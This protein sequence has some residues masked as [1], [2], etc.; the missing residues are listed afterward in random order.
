MGKLK[1][2]RALLLFSLDEPE[3]SIGPPPHACLTIRPLKFS[4]ASQ[5]PVPAYPARAGRDSLRFM[6]ANFL[7]R[8]TDSLI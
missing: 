3:S 1:W 2:N 5:Y 8:K 7:K 4:L 6:K